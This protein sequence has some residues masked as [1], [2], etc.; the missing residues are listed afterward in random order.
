MTQNFAP[1]TTLGRF[2]NPGYEY[3]MGIYWMKEAQV[4]LS[5]E[6]TRY[7]LPAKAVLRACL[8]ID[9]YVNDMGRKVDPDW[10]T[11]DEETTPIKERLTRIN[12]NLKQPIDL[13]QTIWKETLLFFRLR[14]QLNRFELESIYGMPEAEVPEIFKEIEQKYPIRMI[15]AITEE[16]IQHLL[17]ITG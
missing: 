15:H 10:E 4:V 1:T 2:Y 5:S 9:G 11:I 13:N 3:L 14:E 16:A 12:K 17:N 6:A 7:Y 8:A